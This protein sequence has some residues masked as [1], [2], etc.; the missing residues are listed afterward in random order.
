MCFSMKKMLLYLC[1]FMMAAVLACAPALAEVDAFSS[2]SVAD[3]YA[4]NALTGDDLM[5][6]KVGRPRRS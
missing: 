1:A 3:F 5:N 2:A 6:A 4:A